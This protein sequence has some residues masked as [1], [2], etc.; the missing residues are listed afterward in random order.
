MHG[1]IKVALRRN[2]AHATKHKITFCCSWR[3]CCCTGD[4]I[5]MHSDISCCFTRLQVFWFCHWFVL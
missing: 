5:C 2:L 3:C 4:Q 1:N